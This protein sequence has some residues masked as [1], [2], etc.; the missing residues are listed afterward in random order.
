MPSTDTV[1]SITNCYRLIVS[2]SDPVHSF[3]MK[4]SSRNAQLSQLGLV[5]I[6]IIIIIIILEFDFCPGPHG[7]HEDA[8]CRNGIF[9]Y[10]C[11]C[12][13]GFQ[14]GCS[15]KNIILVM[16]LMVVMV[17]ELIR[18]M[19]MKKAMILVLRAN[20]PGNRV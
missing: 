19:V 11:Q 1:S 13:Q 6:T 4:F 16:A 17:V 18:T 15:Y 2:Y 8:T 20:K 5:I 3:M 7:C 9:N 12:Y 10:T 14:V